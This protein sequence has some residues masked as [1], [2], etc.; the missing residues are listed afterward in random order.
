LPGVQVKVEKLGE[1]TIAGVYAEG[2]R[3]TRF[4]P[5]GTVGNDK[6]IVSVSDRWVAEDLKIPLATTLDDP[7]QREASQV[8]KLDRAQ[9]DPILFQ[10]PADFTVREVSPDS[11]QR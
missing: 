9:P 10:I 6:P 2:R 3:V 11:P 4:R 7:R 8:T 1:K 5:S